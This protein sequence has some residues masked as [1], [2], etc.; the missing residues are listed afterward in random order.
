MSHVGILSDALKSPPPPNT[1]QVPASL[2][3]L[4]LI[5]MER[6]GSPLNLGHLWH[7][8]KRHCKLPVNFFSEIIIVF[9]TSCH[10]VPV[11]SQPTT[12]GS[13]TKPTTI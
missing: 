10:T 2:I 8:L 7:P 9:V 5:L 13:T 1:I 11:W 12:S 4:S 6:G 3:C